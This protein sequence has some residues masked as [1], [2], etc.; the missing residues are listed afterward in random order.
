[1]KNMSLLFFIVFLLLFSFKV[2]NFLDLSILVL[3]LV[4]S[5]VIF[6]NKKNFFI[7][8]DIRIIFYFLL[9]SIIYTGMISIFNGG[10]EYIWFLKMTKTLILSFLIFCLAFYLNIKRFTYNDI[11]KVIVIS[12]ITHSIVI[13]LNISFDAFREIIYSITGYQPRGPE[14]SRSPGLT[15]SFN[16]TSI[17]HMFALYLLIFYFKQ[18]S[19]IRIIAFITIL[20]SVFFLGRFITYIALVMIIIGLIIK[21]LLD[22]KYKLF[23]PGLMI[24][25]F[26]TYILNLN[27]SSLDLNN[28]LDQILFNVSH[29]TEPL[30]SIGD[31][32]GVDNYSQETL[33]SHLYISDEWSTVIFGNSFSGHIGIVGGKGETDSDL[34]FI[35]SINANGIILTSLIYLLYLFIIYRSYILKYDW[36]S[37]FFIVVLTLA[38]SFKETGLFTSSATPLLFLVYFFQ[39][40]SKE[41]LLSI[42]NKQRIL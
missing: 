42:Q 35:N 3:I 18:K 7:Y 12:V 23:F 1:M 17:V 10:I 38:L 19:I 29:F 11:M 5:N 6:V 25:M 39:I 14:W 24:I 37:I 22:R 40:I 20:P 41:K 13:Y 9:G 8:S 4:A 16:S 32:G 27:V 34:G 31:S 21:L 36:K 15:I 26:F 30:K 28:K 2:F 33:D